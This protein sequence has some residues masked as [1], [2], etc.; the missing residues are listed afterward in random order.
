MTSPEQRDPKDRSAPAPAPEGSS[1]R[2][3]GRSAAAGTC[4]TRQRAT[5]CFGQLVRLFH[6]VL[7]LSV[8][9]QPKTAIRNAGKACFCSIQMGSNG[10]TGK[11]TPPGSISGR[12]R[13]AHLSVTMPVQGRGERTLLL[14]VSQDRGELQQAGTYTA[15]HKG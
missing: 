8:L 15:A 13:D 14:Q 10:W 12:V 1:A 5:C 4:I 6:R 3:L 7:N 11:A 9:F 2:G